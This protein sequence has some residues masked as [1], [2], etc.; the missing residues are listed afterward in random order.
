MKLTGGMKTTFAGA[1]SSSVVTQ[2]EVQEPKR[3]S[4]AE[5]NPS[6]MAATRTLIESVF[7]DKKMVSDGAVLHRSGVRVVER[8]VGRL[9]RSCSLT[10][11]LSATS[12]HDNAKK[13]GESFRLESQAV[14]QDVYV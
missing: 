12:S 3:K 10:S 7:Y 4:I 6:S 2:V 11:D 13:I 14:S 5:L 8:N 9:G 1:R